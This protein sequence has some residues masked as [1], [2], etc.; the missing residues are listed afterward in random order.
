MKKRP[1]LLRERLPELR[2]DAP[3]RLRG[4]GA[5]PSGE[6]PAGTLELTWA[7]RRDGRG[8]SIEGCLHIYP[9]KTP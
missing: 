4:R 3:V 8:G 9:F 1:D 5:A 6:E 2:P 7:D